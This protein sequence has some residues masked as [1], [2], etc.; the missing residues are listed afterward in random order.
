[1]SRSIDSRVV[2]MRFDNKQFE[3]GAKQTLSTLQR[4]KDSLKNLVSPNK[5]T[6]LLG[7]AAKNSKSSIDQ[8]SQSVGA[9]EK[10]FSFLG[11]T[12]RN[13]ENKI[14]DTITGTLGNAINY[15]KSGIVEGGIRRATN[16][17]NAHYQ[18]QTL[19]KDEEKVQKVMD[20]AMES[21]DGTAYGFDEAAKAASMFAA[22]GIKSGE[23]MTNA[24]KGIAGTAA[25]TNQE[26]ERVSLIFTT[27]AGQGRLMGDQLLQ[28]SSMGLNAPASIATFFNEIGDGT[29]KA[30]KKVKKAVTEITNGAKVTEK[31]I[32]EMVTDGQISFEIFAE[33]MYSAFGESAT[34]ANETFNGSLAN[35]RAALSRIGAE[36]VAPLIAQNSKVVKLIN[37]A[38]TKI[39]EIKKALVFDK[40][41]KNV[42]AYSKRFTDA[43]L[44]MAKGLNKWLKSLDIAKGMKVF[45]NVVDSV[46][47][48]FKA[49]WSV[50]EPLGKAFADVFLNFNVKDVIKATKEVKKFTEG[51][52]LSEKQ[53]KNLH[54]AFKGVFDVIKLLADGFIGLVSAILNVNLPVSDLSNGFFDL[55]SILGKALSSFTDWIRESK[56]VKIAFEGISTVAKIVGNAIRGLIGIAKSF[57]DKAVEMKV[58]DTVLQAFKSLGEFAA[59]YIDAVANK[60]KEFV[61][62]VKEWAGSSFIGVGEKLKNLFSKIWDVLSNFKMD[63]ISEKTND[64]SNSFKGMAD[65]FKKN[66]GGFVSNLKSFGEKLKEVFDFSE[67]INN[68]NKFKNLVQD[69]ANWFK[70]IFG[71]L[72]GDFSFGGAIAGAGGIGIILLVKKIS[73]LFATGLEN[74]NKITE[75]VPKLIDSLTG[76]LKAWQA[77]IKA[78]TLKKTAEAILILA[79][80]LV[81]LGFTDT[82]KAMEASKALSVIA[83]V[84]FAGVSVLMKAVNQGR[85]LSSRINYFSKFLG[86]SMNNL[87]KAVKWKAIGSTFKDFGESIIM[88]AGSIIAIGLMYRHDKEA[89]LEAEKLVALIATVMVGIIGSLVL[90][91]KKLSVSGAGVLKISG[92]VL[93]L[94]VSI[95]VIIGALKKVLDLELPEDYLLRFGILEGVI[96]NLILITIALGGASRIAASNKIQSGPIVAV[97][98]ALKLCVGTLKDVFKIELPSD[99]LEKFGILTALFVEFA[100]LIVAMGGAQRLAGGVIKG[101]GVLLALAFDIGVITTAL[102]VLSIIPAEGMFKGALALG[103]VLLSLAADL[104][105][106]SQITTADTAKTVLN[107]AIIVGSITAALGVLSFVS[108]PD[109]AKGATALGAMLIALAFDFLAVSKISNQSVWQSILGMVGIVVSITG[110]LFI[111]SEQPWQG[112]LAAGVAMGATLLAFA[113]AFAIIGRTSGMSLPKAAMFLSFTLASIPIGVALDQLANQPWKG[114]L[115]AS[116][117]ISGVL[118]AFTAAFAIISKS[119]VKLQS[120]I[121]FVAASVALIPI[122]AA[123]DMLAGQSWSSILPG[124]ASLGIVVTSIGVAMGIMGKTGTKALV[125][126]A[127]FVGGALAII[128]ITAALDMLAGESWSSILPGAASL[129]IVAASLAGALSIMGAVGPKVLVGTVSFVAAAVA[130]IPVSG[131]IKQLSGLSWEEVA[132]GLVALAGGLVVIAGAAVVGASIAPGLLAIGAAMVVFGAGLAAVGAALPVFVNGLSVAIQALSAFIQNLGNIVSEMVDAGKNLMLGLAKGILSGV[133]A[134]GSVVKEIGKGIVD[135]IK[136]VLGIHSPSTVFE[137]LGLNVDEGFAKGILGGEGNINSAIDS[138]FN[139]LSDQIDLES[140]F[141]KGEEG[142]SLFGEGLLSGEA[143]IDSIMNQIADATGTDV[144]SFTDVG[145]DGSSNLGEGLLSGEKDVDSIIKDLADATGTDVGSFT[146]VGKDAS[147]KYGSGLKSGDGN[148][149]KTIKQLA[150]ATNTDVSSYSNLGKK[151]ANKF[152]KGVTEGVK[153]GSSS[154]ASSVA[155]TLKKAIA[156]SVEGTNFGA[157]GKKVAKAISEGIK[158]EKDKV[159][160]ATNEVLKATTSAIKDQNDKF[161]NSGSKTISSYA[162]GIKSKSSEVSNSVSKIIKKM[163]N[164]IKSSNKDFKSK[165]QDTIKHFV[166]GIKSKQNDAIK[167]AKTTATKMI[168]EFESNA[169]G[170]QSPGKESANRYIESM[171]S[172]LNSGMSSVVSIMSNKGKELVQGLAR[173]INANSGIARNAASQLARQIDQQIKQDLDIHSPSKVAE[174][175]GKQ[176]VDGFAQGIMYNTPKAVSAANKL[177]KSTKDTLVEG[178]KQINEATVKY[179]KD[180]YLSNY[181]EGLIKKTKD[182]RQKLKGLNK[183]VKDWYIQQEGYDAQIKSEKDY[184]KQL[185]EIKRNGIDKEKY[186]NM[187]LKTFRKEMLDSYQSIMD[188][189]HNQIAQEQQDVFKQINIFSELDKSLLKTRQE[190]ADEEYKA[191]K[192]EEKAA[193][194]REKN[195]ETEKK[196]NKAKREIVKTLNELSKENEKALEAYERNLKKAEKRLQGTN[197]WDYLIEQGIESLPMLKEINKMTDAELKMTIETFDSSLDTA[198]SIAKIK[199]G[200]VTAETKKNIDEMFGIG[201]AGIKQGADQNQRKLSLEDQ[202]WKSLLKLKKQGSESEKYLEMDLQTFREGVLEETNKIVEDYKNQFNSVK[203]SIMKEMDLFTEV[204]QKQA[205]TKDELSEILSDQIKAYKEYSLIMDNLMRRLEGTNLIGYIKD[206]G[207]DSLDQL[208]VIYN[209]TDE[210]LSAYSDLYDKKLEAAGVVANVRLKDVKKETEANL[211]ELFGASTNINLNDFLTKFDG[212]LKSLEDFL[213][214]LTESVK[215]STQSL[216]QEVDGL[217]GGMNR[218]TN[219][220]LSIFIESASNEFKGFDKTLASAIGQATEPVSVAAGTVALTA[221]EAIR[222]TSG[223]FK[224]AGQETGESYTKGLSQLQNESNNTGKTLATQAVSGI[225]SKQQAFT[226]KGNKEGGNYNTGIKSQY[227]NANQTGTGL[228]N[229]TLKGIQSQYDNARETGVKLIKKTLKGIE[230]KLEDFKVDGRISGENYV[231]G[232]DSQKDIAISLGRSMA[233][234][235]LNEAREIYVPMFYAGRGAGEGFVEGIRS[236]I[237]AARA[238]AEELANAAKTSTSSTLDEHSPSKVMMEIGDYAGIGFVNGLLGCVAKAALASEELGEAAQNGATGYLGGLGDIIT[239]EFSVNPTITPEVDLTNVVKSVDDITRMFNN[240]IKITSADVEIIDSSIRTQNRKSN[241]SDNSNNLRKD[242]EDAGN[243]FNFT[244]NNYSPKALSRSDIYRQTRNQFSLFE[245]R[246]SRI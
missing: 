219:E 1:M 140:M 188:E 109:L 39:D 229:E 226:N 213:L 40:E 75:S 205:K 216:V 211:Q 76:S 136:S 121:G 117:S 12:I 18:L 173:G 129:A 30:S 137:A 70:E 184:W 106:T 144:S 246:V 94:T 80:A 152:T 7:S 19:L 4:L 44:G 161:K 223:D 236:Q 84:M 194:Q 148:I 79:G 244:Q 155:Q 104:W 207:V 160:S 206:L 98:I 183:D 74:L 186:L 52:K 139:G 134:V 67:V 51:L 58:V 14:R 123:L 78:D 234:G 36:F 242:N 146:K 164:E 192:K 95:G 17:E 135:T 198:L 28:L 179:L 50:I 190:Q 57:V 187:D 72:F 97:A 105:A 63:A 53:S 158:S 204:T 149:K 103:G 191:A 131:A 218:T 110:S 107:M 193:K 199:M 13:V 170:F 147:T 176:V 212:T 37:T 71:G 32:R 31:D 66:V 61:G 168:K 29:A 238:A 60:L 127:A 113:E 214:K 159:K 171:K 45:Y 156:S 65:T 133:K 241:E 54:D 197:L 180:D 6:D 243:T 99:W 33:A 93:A 175:R 83:G 27:V 112:M 203:D 232:L 227:S 3:S 16:I 125:G 23:S 138:V 210:E 174:E 230:S 111:L 145:K 89:L 222:E 240:A 77:N 157:S 235:V 114:M 21:V 2:E 82:D 167:M 239:D 42:E 153:S 201:E 8:I 55:I 64:F 196:S 209:M 165:G 5:A 38:R 220:K 81:V 200:D 47:N 163:G 69:F 245:T 233:Q 22:S 215:G 24:L 100:G 86:K 195:N 68:L 56:L 49:L 181:I 141:P 130:L 118:L 150:D 108:I 90:I 177:T 20:N 88:V 128:P 120:V 102:M 142:S 73:D 43:V 151:A 35:M 9:L 48:I 225:E 101:V 62:V 182:T 116:A 178:V 231:N 132:R 189:Y 143:D 119:N 59:P 25:M 96:A 172:A 124:A 85:D 237:S 34:R 126:V 224:S 15:V 208:K 162:S 41:A 87:A 221:V 10:R 115:A 202:Y 46:I 122:S 92:S 11:E 26:Y 217:L 228:A 91:E 166:D 169:K 185:L 154:A